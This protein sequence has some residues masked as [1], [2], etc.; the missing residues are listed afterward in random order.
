M[1]ELRSLCF[2]NEKISVIV[3]VKNN[4]MSDYD[5]TVEAVELLRTG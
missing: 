5:M 3:I 2:D 1:T 4:K